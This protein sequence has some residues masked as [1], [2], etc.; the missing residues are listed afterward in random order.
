MK[1]A[2]SERGAFVMQDPSLLLDCGEGVGEMDADVIGKCTPARQGF[3]RGLQGY[4]GSWY[5]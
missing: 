2:G 3:C 5:G 1:R 4:E